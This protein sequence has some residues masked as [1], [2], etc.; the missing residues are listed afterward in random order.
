MKINVLDKYQIVPGT[1]KDSRYWEIFEWRKVETKKGPV[2]K[3][4]SMQR[5]P[6]TLRFAVDI[7]AEKELMAFKEECDVF[8]AARKLGDL[9]ESMEAAMREVDSVVKPS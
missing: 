6:T 1:S 8:A 2:M 4:V 3:W 9:Y 5:F 7:L